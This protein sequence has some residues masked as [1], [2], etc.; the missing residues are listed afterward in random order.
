M[1]ISLSAQQ[2]LRL[3]SF[4][5]IVAF[6][7]FTPVIAFSQDEQSAGQEEE[8]IN[9]GSNS[10]GQQSERTAP[11]VGEGPWQNSAGSAVGTTDVNTNSGSSAGSA[12]RPGG[13]PTAA[14]RPDPGGN[15]D[16][17]FDNNMNLVFL[18]AGLI[19]AFWIAK[20]RLS[21]KTVTIKSN[22]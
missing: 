10:Q 2:F 8:L 22:K 20:R 14:Q 11:V 3:C 5:L 12:N 21:D 15:P 13:R 9:S 4:S 18:A 17:P 6:I 7:M 19:F 1:K 16:V